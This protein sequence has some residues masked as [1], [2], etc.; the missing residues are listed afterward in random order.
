G[1]FGFFKPSWWRLRKV[2]ASRYDFAAHAVKPSWTRVL[3]GL[4][5]EYDTAAA[6]TSAEHDAHERWGTSDVAGL[7]RT[8]AE[9]HQGEAKLDGTCRALRS[10]LLKSDVDAAARA[11]VT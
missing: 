6:V 4:R 7:L 1:A 10:R 8:V 3:D 11:S 5:A 9:L 2:L